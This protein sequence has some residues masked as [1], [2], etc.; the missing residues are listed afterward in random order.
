MQNDKLEIIIP[1]SF[2]GHRADSAIQALVSD[3]SRVK[4]QKWIKEGHILSNNRFIAPKDK[5]VGG[6]IISIQIQSDEK[7]NQFIPENIPINIEYEDED[8]MV[9]NKPAGLVVHPGAGNWS[10]TL[11]N[12][13]IF[14]RP[15]N[16]KLARCGIVHRLDKN[17]SGLMV[18]AKNE[19]S[20]INLVKQ[21]Q[22]KRVYREYRAV[23][24]GQLSKKDTIN[25]PIGR[26]PSIR[27][28]MAVNRING[29]ESITHYEVLEKFGVCSYLRC[30]LETGRTHQ[31]RVHMMHNLSPIV[32][33][34]T[35]G[36]KKIIPIREVS[37]KLRNGTV[38]F[39]RQALHAI[40]LGLIHPSSNKELK[41]D[42]NLPEDMKTLLN[43]VRNESPLTKQEINFKE[44]EFYYG[45]KYGE[46][47]DLELYDE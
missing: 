10:G 7:S 23:V 42:I 17:T 46:G 2:S 19:L 25:E 43:L 39:P 36:L 13:I 26:H 21:L 31:I 1:N 37:N 41:W 12:A 5:L 11:L 15:N 35:Y 47:E 4:I 32:G 8:I 20:Q 30:I 9:I 27:I 44:S 18:V 16:S 24:W 34:P 38:N 22:S 45:E 29:K 14:H 33:D 40:S 28:K 6:E 3:F